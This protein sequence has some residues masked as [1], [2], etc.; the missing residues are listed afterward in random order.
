MKHPLTV[1]NTVR[2]SLYSSLRAED[3]FSV[4]PGN[5]ISFPFQNGSVR[6]TVLSIAEDQSACDGF[7]LF[8]TVPLQKSPYSLMTVQPMELV[9]P[10]GAEP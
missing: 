4:S 8:E 1:K 5:G 7:I 3:G 10:A 9:D 6:Q 2:G